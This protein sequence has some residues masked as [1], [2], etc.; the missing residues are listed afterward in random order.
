MACAFLAAGDAGTDESDATACELLRPAAAVRVPRVAA[1]DDYVAL[2]EVRRQA[3]DE[4]ID[5]G[6]RPH[7]EQNRPRAPQGG[8]Q[9]L[10]TVR[11]DD[12]GSPRRPC[13]KLVHP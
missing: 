1:V 6:S 5:H 12:C 4:P 9:L 10:E 8:G 3:F 7:H 11:A 13:E 2:L